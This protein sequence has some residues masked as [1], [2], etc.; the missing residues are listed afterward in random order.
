METDLSEN[1][2]VYVGNLDNK[3]SEEILHE[4]FLQA[5]PLKKV[6]IP[7]DHRTKKPQRFAFVSFKHVISVDYAIELLRGIRLFG[8][9]LQISRKK[10]KEQ[11]VKDIYEDKRH[12]EHF[13]EQQRSHRNYTMQIAYPPPTSME[14]LNQRERLFVGHG[15]SPYSN[16]MIASSS[17]HMQRSQSFH[18]PNTA[19]PLQQNS[20]RCDDG[21]ELSGR[22]KSSPRHYHH[23][24]SQKELNRSHSYNSPNRIMNHGDRRF[25]KH[26]NYGE[27][28]QRRDSR[29]VV[30]QHSRSSPYERSHRH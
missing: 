9:S 11:P 28:L 10:K 18:G 30:V 4:L 27:H 29:R 6:R 13:S 19:S 14:A 25:E 24:D 21:I 12:V 17:Q 20:L 8:C 22:K 5:G 26:P 1:L 2:T 16:P 7:I 23:H 15:C 3:I